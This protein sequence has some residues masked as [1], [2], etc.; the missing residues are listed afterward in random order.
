M[1]TV[2]SVYSLHL[3]VLQVQECTGACPVI[4]S[5]IVLDDLVDVIS[6]SQAVMKIDIQGFEHYAFRCASRLFDAIHFTHIFMEWEIMRDFFVDFNHT[7]HDKLLVEQMLSFLL[8]RHFRPYKLVF[9]GAEPLDPK[10]WSSW[11][12]NI[13]WLRL[14]N[15]DELSYLTRSHH[16]NWPL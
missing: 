9:D 7:S 11:P 12:V 10:H 8:V 14:A 3:F 2:I 6:F 15:P 16:K 13:V 1:L 5:T 4:I